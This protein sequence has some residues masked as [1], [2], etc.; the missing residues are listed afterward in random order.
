ML[1]STRIAPHLILS[2]GLTFNKYRST[3]NQIWTDIYIVHEVQSTEKTVEF[4][5]DE[6]EKDICF[7]I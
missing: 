5:F 6:T 3:L 1:C 7:I 4:I 2:S